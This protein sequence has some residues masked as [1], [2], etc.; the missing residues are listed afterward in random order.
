MGL[1]MP[2]LKRTRAGLWT[3]RKEIPAD[4]RGFIGKR[5]DKPTW[6]AHLSQAAAKAE[7][8]TW[9]SSLEE[10]IEAVRRHSMAPAERFSH[11]WVLELVANWYRAQ[12]AEFEDDPG[13]PIGWDEWRQTLV[14]ADQVSRTAK[15]VEVEVQEVLVAPGL[16]ITPESQAAI[17]E[18]LTNAFVAFSNLMRRRAEGDCSTDKYAERFPVTTAAK[19]P[20]P[21]QRTQNKAV[22]ITGLFDAYAAERQLAASTIKA[23]KRMVA[24]FVTFV[25]HDDAHRAAPADV[26][27]WKD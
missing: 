16:N 17:T 27:G 22:T 6:P 14:D 23:W 13:S 24:A 10:R 1:R 2:T 3:A 11:R 12:V 19:S 25:S 5:E 26:V 15:K 18:E 8:G 9:L 21:P 4:V 20:S 7:F